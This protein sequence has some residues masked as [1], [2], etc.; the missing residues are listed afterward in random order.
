MKGGAPAHKLILGTGLYGRTFLLTNS[1]NFA[2][3]APS[4]TTAFAGPYTRED[5]FLGYNEVI[6]YFDWFVNDLHGHSRDKKKISSW[7]IITYKKHL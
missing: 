2:M 3:N 5:G 4:Q 7:N 6:F 1:S